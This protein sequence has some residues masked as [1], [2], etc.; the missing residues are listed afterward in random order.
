MGLTHGH[1]KPALKCSSDMGRWGKKTLKKYRGEESISRAGR[2]Q[3]DQEG[4]VTPHSEKRPTLSP[5]G[6]ASELVPGKTDAGLNQG[7][8]PAVFST[9]AVFAFFDMGPGYYRLLNNKQEL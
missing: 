5:P 9:N 4:N 2:A 8:V 1:Q 3:E 6:P 7:R